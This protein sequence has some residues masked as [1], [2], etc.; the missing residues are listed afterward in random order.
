MTVGTGFKVLMAV[1]GDGFVARGPDDPMK[2]TGQTDKA[3]FKLLTL[4]GDTNKVLAGRRTAELMSKLAD[5]EVVAISRTHHKGITLQEAAWAHRGAWLVGGLDVVMAAL[6][7]NLVERVVLCQTA[8]RLGRGVP[9][10]PLLNWLARDCHH[11]VK[12]GEIY[13]NI[14]LGVNHGA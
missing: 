5:R 3:I 7:A 2:W 8:V 4:M 9:V 13:A 11:T 10:N 6:E 12:L 1:S 14:Y